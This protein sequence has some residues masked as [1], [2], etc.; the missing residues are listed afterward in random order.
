MLRS[1]FG[2]GHPLRRL[3]F[4]VR[5]LFATVT[6][7]FGWAVH[8]ITGTT[9]AWAHQ[10][11]IRLFSASRGVTNDLMSRFLSLRYPA[12][13]IVPRAGVLSG[14]PSEEIT[15]A[16]DVMRER[17]Y[18]VL[19]QRVPSATCDRLLEFA[20]TQP[21]LVYPRDNQEGTS[22]AAVY[23]PAHP[24]APHYQFKREGSDQPS[25]RASA[26]GRPAPY[27]RTA[28]DS[29]TDPGLTEMS[30]RHSAHVFSVPATLARSLT[31]GR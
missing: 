6:L 14:L 20:L 7:P 27:P 9:P 15:R 8:A 4:L 13:T 11:M 18:F 23:D 3:K 28:I 21:A 10:S 16:A 31:L 19:P 5:V 30:R 17:G 29:L 22:V 12:R 24:L 25:R 1:F 26:D 2:G